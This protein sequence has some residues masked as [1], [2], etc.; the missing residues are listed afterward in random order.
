MQLH[1]TIPTN[2][3]SDFRFVS[4]YRNIAFIKN[5]QQQKGEEAVPPLPKIDANTKLYLA[6]S[7]ISSA[8]LP[9]ISLTLPCI[10]SLA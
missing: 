1:S 8:V 4:D 5:S 2:R 3:K 10:L 7:M 6:I 9:S